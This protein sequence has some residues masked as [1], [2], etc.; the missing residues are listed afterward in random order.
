MIKEKDAKEIMKKAKAKGIPMSY[1]KR[2][3]NLTGLNI[4]DLPAAFLPKVFQ[5]IEE[6]EA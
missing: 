6:Y 4:T 1:I 5:W 2:T 3:W